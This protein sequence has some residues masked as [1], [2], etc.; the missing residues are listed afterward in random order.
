MILLPLLIDDNPLS[1]GYYRLRTIDLDGQESLSPVI[2]ITR[3]KKG[4]ALLNVYPVPT[5]STA[6]IE[7]VSNTNAT[8]EV[9]LVDVAGRIIA[10]NNITASEGLNTHLIQV[11]HLAA[12]IY[13][14]RMNDGTSELIGRIVK[15]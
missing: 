13:F 14:V 4:F 1:Q 8:I 5:K 12:G 3:D 10:T 6:T 7:F 15:D 2:S 11:E 9:T